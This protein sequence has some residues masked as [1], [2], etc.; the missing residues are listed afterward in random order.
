LVPAD[1][2]LFPELKNV[3][4]GKSFSDLED[5]KSSLKKILEYVLNNGRSIGNSVNYWREITL[6]NSR[7]LMSA[8]L[9][10]IF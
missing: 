1:F 5:I 7:S 9:K 3:L 2:C 6:K 8:A 10:I 4:E